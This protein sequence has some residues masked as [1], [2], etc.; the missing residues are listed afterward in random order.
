MYQ[1]ISLKM[2]E[3]PFTIVKSRQT[4]PIGYLHTDGVIHNVSGNVRIS[5]EIHLCFFSC[6]CRW[7]CGVLRKVRADALAARNLAFSPWGAA[8]PKD[9]VCGAHCKAELSWGREGQLGKVS[10]LQS[11]TLT[12]LLHQKNWGARQRK[13]RK[14]VLCIRDRTCMF[15]TSQ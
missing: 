13:G 12:E 4:V 8:A 7:H 10:C 11:L 5:S 15:V 14:K 9:R 6:N 2:R 3:E 1:N